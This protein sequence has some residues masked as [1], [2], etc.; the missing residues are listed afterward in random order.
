DHELLAR[1]F[2]QQVSDDLLGS[3]FDEYFLQ[4]AAPRAVHNRM[5][6][7]VAWIVAAADNC[8]TATCKISIFG[9]AFGLEAAEA[10][11]R[12]EAGARA[13]LRVTLLDLDPQG[14]D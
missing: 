2:E 14:I 5:K 10:G 11:Q 1:I 7:M 4:Q 12:L 13:R 9:S 3:L 6:M 8:Q